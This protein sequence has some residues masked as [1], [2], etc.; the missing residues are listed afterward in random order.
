LV[1]ALGQSSKTTL[2]EKYEV[3]FYPEM[4]TRLPDE[5]EKFTPRPAYRDLG[6]KQPVFENSDF[7]A[8][9]LRNWE[10]EGEAFANQPTWHDNAVARLKSAAAVQG[11][12]WVGTYEDNPNPG[13]ITGA[14]QGDRVRGTL[15]SRAFEVTHD[16]LAL[17]IGGGK[18]RKNLYVAFEVEGEEVARYTGRKLEQMRPVVLDTTPY[19]GRQMTIVIVDHSSRGWGHVNV[20]GFAWLLDDAQAEAAMARWSKRKRKRKR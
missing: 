4:F 5:W 9:D 7:E 18:D 8:G 10:A 15:R 14:R 16:S 13:V 12:W 6:P 3:A 19:R 1:V 20:D 2:M 11:D 17:R